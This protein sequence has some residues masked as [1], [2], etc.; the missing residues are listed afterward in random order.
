MGLRRIMVVALIALPACTTM[1]QVEAPVQF[2]EQ[3]NPRQVRVHSA[4]GD[5][6]V[7]KDPQ[8]RGDTI[9]GFESMLREEVRFS[10]NGI[11]R[12]EAVQPDKKRTTL[13]VGAMT[14]LGGAGIYMIANAS[15]GNKLICDNYDVANR[16]VTRNPS[17]RWGLPAR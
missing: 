17:I 12:M 8:L 6:F 9:F 5:L 1:R 2:L 11:R 3:N 4:D 7:L 10:V 14:L 15:N 16:C 13:F